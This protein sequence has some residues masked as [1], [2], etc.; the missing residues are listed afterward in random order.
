MKK[1]SS[2]LRKALSIVLSLL[3]LVPVLQGIIPI[4]LA[5]PAKVPAFEDYPSAT[6]S[7]NGAYWIWTTSSANTTTNTWADFR[8][9]FTLATKP[10]SAIFKIAADT[11]YWLW[12]NGEMAIREGN[13]LRGPTGP[14]SASQD[15]TYYDE[16]DLAK[17][18][19]VGPNTIAIEVN[20]WN[21]SSGHNNSVRSG[22]IVDADLIDSA[23]G[24][25]I[26]SSD[27]QWWGRTNTCYGGSQSGLNAMPRLTYNAQNETQIIDWYMPSY[28]PGTGNGWSRPYNQVAAGAAPWRGLYK[29][30][31][32]QW[33]DYGLTI[34]PKSEWINL[35]SNR[36]YNFT[37]YHM[38]VTS[39]CTR[40]A[41]WLPYNA[42]F[43]PYLKL[44]SATTAGQT[45]IMTTDTYG[46]GSTTSSYT[47]KA[48][49]QEYEAKNWIN[50]DKLYFDIPSGILNYVEELGFRESGYALNMVSHKKGAFSHIRAGI[51]ADNS[52]A[53]FPGWFDSVID[54]STDWS[55]PGKTYPFTGGHTWLASQVSADNNYYD[56]LWKKAVRTLYLTC[57]DIFM[58]C[59]D[60]ERGQYIGDAV[61]EFE[62][63]YYS[64]GPEFY[65]LVKKAYYE[66]FDW[67][68]T[69]TVSG[70][71][72]YVTSNVRPGKLGQ[73]LSSQ[74]LS[75][76][77]SLSDYYLYT[78][79]TDC[80]EHVWQK[81]YNYLQN[82]DILTTGNYIGLLGMRA[83]GTNGGYSTL[84]EW[85]DWGSNI[86]KRLLLQNEYYMCANA[87][88]NLA[89]KPEINITMTQTQKDFLE[90]RI[91]TIKDNYEK[92]WDPNVNAY[93]D[94]DYN[95]TAAGTS[96]TNVDDRGNAFSV[97][98]GL[99]PPERYPQMREL[100]MGGGSVHAQ[101][102][103]NASIYLEKYVQQALCLMGYVDDAMNRTV[104][105][106]AS[107]INADRNSTLPENWTFYNGASSGSTNT[108]NHGWS[109]GSMISASRYQTGV[110]PTAPGYSKWHIVPQMGHFLHIDTRVPAI[111]GNI[112]VVLGRNKADNTL[113]MTVTAPNGNNAEFYV[114]IYN[115]D[116]VV[117]CRSGNA[118]FLREERKYNQ[119][120]WVFSG[121]T[122]AVAT[123]E[124]AAGIDDTGFTY[125]YFTNTLP[126]A[127]VQLSVNG[128]APVALPSRLRVPAGEPLKLKVTTN[129][130]EEYNF[131]S[132]AGD[133][134]STNSEITF[135]PVDDETLYNLTVNFAAIYTYRTITFTNALPAAGV[136]LSVNGGTPIALPGTLRVREG[137]PY[138]LEVF[139]SDT[140]EYAFVGWSG[141]IVAST[142]K[143]AFTP[144]GNM[145]LSITFKEIY[146]YATITLGRTGISSNS[147]ALLSVNGA[148]ATALPSSLRLR[149][150]QPYTLKVTSGNSEYS[151]VSWSG[152]ITSSNNEI[153]ITPQGNMNLT[154]NFK[155]DA[156]N[157]TFIP[158]GVTRPGSSY[159][160]NDITISIDGGTAARLG[161]S[162]TQRLGNSAEHTVEI[163]VA[164]DVDYSFSHWS[165]GGEVFSTDMPLKFTPTGDVS[166]T[167]NFKW[168]DYESLSYASAGASVLVSAQVN[169]TWAA[170]NLIN[171]SI[172][173]AASSNLGWSSTSLGSTTPSSPPWFAVNLGSAKTFDRFHIY[174]RMEI[175]APS[176][177]T[178]CNFPIEFLLEY[179]N[180][181]FSYA[182]GVTTTANT[183]SLNALTWTTVPGG[184]GTNG[185]FVLTTAQVPFL[186]PFVLQLAKPITARYIRM[187][188]YRTNDR[189]S[190]DASTYYL[191][192]R[193][194]GVYSTFPTYTVSFDSAGGSAV[195][196]AKAMYTTTVN[197]PANPTRFG[198]TF[199]D[200]YLD[201]AVYDF[202]TPVAGDITLVA[203][204]SRNPIT[205]LKI[206]NLLGETSAA[207]VTVVRNSTVQFGYAINADAIREGIVWTIMPAGY[208]TVDAETGLVTV[209]N[210]TG[211]VVLTATDSLN[212]ATNSIVLR[213]V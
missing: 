170:A 25:R 89:N 46:S 137:Q 72:Y 58:D 85:W 107:I 15:A 11:K 165:I 179:A 195:D 123:Y 98:N 103:E 40:I 50:G 133:V 173:A 7:W 150:G 28:T 109:G 162:V 108:K 204:W 74:V 32:P 3:M 19:V 86:D 67:Q 128:A 124:F 105:R 166:L 80:V 45:I 191:Q 92:M 63:A 200:W 130:P 188:V 208:A 146:E 148:A 186:K 167:A 83:D 55:A 69:T 8:R 116:Q 43:T 112:D 151:F 212:G 125:V 6:A 158:A 104:K 113:E 54:Y 37:S 154:V 115:E 99:C 34:V 49:A 62:E 196:E 100:F 23:T 41:V 177:T 93:R 141:D 132:W 2:R 205:S 202:D 1:A 206:T 135:T 172:V 198:Y 157:V 121:N 70:R 22:L 122:A 90:G 131:V 117:I 149:I 156:S 30:P 26:Q 201:D 145:A 164:N 10:V 180:G 111:I 61:N 126:E 33:M 118:T 60:R 182:T 20:A 77:Y 16:V 159:T 190:N 210:K 9:D 174:P 94:R 4:A 65:P 76:I 144:A 73:E 119:D 209:S 29:R 134:I 52:Y 192:I 147:D 199:I 139:T 84:S 114:P 203:Q 169:T 213:I 187:T 21:N 184:T 152:D 178:S 17:W 18:L 155:S 79:D 136:T 87:L 207:A 24:N 153:S 75:C 53:N 12:V 71:T 56:E 59:P 82:W 5:E 88:Y 101:P 161:T 138:T 102:H 197:R 27:G 211:T 143:I 181:D 106:H 175:Y 160:Y 64:L 38:A 120:Y 127:G 97:V 176:G 36:D 81:M 140:A 142:P 48:G 171:G 13:L 78:G 51:P 163:K 183:S 57:R 91:K 95:S 168:N 194:F 31:I 129:D 185:R 193:S 14:T 35:G 110:E 66:I 68:F 47:T 39:G 96:T 42:Q 44:S 189:A